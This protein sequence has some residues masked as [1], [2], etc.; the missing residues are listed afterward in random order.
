MT[1]L[2][3]LHPALQL[4]VENVVVDEVLTRQCLTVDR[5]QLLEEAAGAFGLGRQLDQRQVR[6]AGIGVAATSVSGRER[7]VRQTLLPLPG[8]Q[9]G[10]PRGFSAGVGRGRTGRSQ[11]A[12]RQDEGHQ[13]QKR[14]RAAGA[15]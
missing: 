3:L 4:P 11:N 15:F 5:P 12:G 8:N 13:G 7:V 9:R 10:E 1:D 14:K 2:P 6:Q